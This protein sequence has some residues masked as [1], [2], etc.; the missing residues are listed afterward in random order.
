MS[1]T[2]HSLLIPIACIIFA[3][4][5]GVIVFGEP[6]QKFFAEDILLGLAFLAGGTRTAMNPLAPSQAQRGMRFPR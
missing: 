1:L 3:V 2:T 6:G 5:F 4:G